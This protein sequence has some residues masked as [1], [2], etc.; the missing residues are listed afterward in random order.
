MDWIVK[1]F[2]GWI[3]TIHQISF[4][5]RI[6]ENFVVKISKIEQNPRK[7]RNFHPSKLFHY[8][9]GIIYLFDVHR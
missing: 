6:A 8:T 4:F 2:C 1:I 7:P 9:V 5:S 3:I